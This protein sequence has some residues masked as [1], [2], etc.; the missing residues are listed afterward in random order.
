MELRVFKAA[1]STPCACG[2]CKSPLDRLIA[3]VRKYPELLRAELMK[4]GLLGVPAPPDLTQQ[5]R[6]NRAASAPTAHLDRV[7]AALRVPDVTR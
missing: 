3:G 7:K 2:Q 5:V 4:R 1:S 6:A